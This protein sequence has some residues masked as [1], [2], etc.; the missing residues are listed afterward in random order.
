VPTCPG[1]TVHDLVDH[2]GSIHRW[3]AHMVGARSPKRASF[4][5]VDLAKPASDDGLAAWLRDGASVLTDA[6]KNADPD[7]AMW[8]WGA[9]QHVRFWPRRMLF[10]TAIHRADL[11]LAVGATPATG[12]A[13]AVDGIDELLDNIPSAS[14]FAPGVDELRGAG[15][16]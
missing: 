13:S 4:R 11:A 10:E 6:S 9:D 16:T 14:Y 2:A 8:A 1:W 3:A 5:D 7:D 12:A 15:E